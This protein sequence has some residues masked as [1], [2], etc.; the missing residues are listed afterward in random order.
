MHTASIEAKER[1]QQV[2][3]EKQDQRNRAC[4]KAEDEITN[5]YHDK[6]I[7]ALVACKVIGVIIAVLFVTASF[8]TIYLQESNV[9]K[10][11][12]AIVAIIT[13]IQGT[14]PFFKKTTWLTRLIHNHYE[15]KKNLALDDRKKQYL[16]IIDSNSVSE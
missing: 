16:A 8:L 4:K 14:I 15:I 9:L 11:V 5:E 13:C 12:T 3:K 7:R 1:E 2:I 6:E 10:G